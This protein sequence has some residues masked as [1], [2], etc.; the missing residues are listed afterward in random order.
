M[1]RPSPEVVRPVIPK[2]YEDS[3]VA[4]F[5]LNIFIALTLSSLRA[6]FS[7]VR[8]IRRHDLS[9]GCSAVAATAYVPPPSVRSPT[10][11]PL[12][13]YSRRPAALR[14]ALVHDERGLP[15]RHR[16]RSYRAEEVSDTQRSTFG[17]PCDNPLRRHLETPIRHGG[18]SAGFDHALRQQTDYST[19]YPQNY[20]HTNY[21]QPP[22]K[23]RP[24][25]T[26]KIPPRSLRSSVSTAPSLPT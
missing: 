20:P 21:G 19:N 3:G 15:R 22:D 7:S 1:T 10:D 14:H 24:P 26:R 5:L 23:P 17:G 6:L 8:L 16:S 18:W 12:I 4:L 2:R 9:E 13:S 11:Y 25:P